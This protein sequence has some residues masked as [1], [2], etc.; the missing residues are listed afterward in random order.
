MSIN[1]INSNNNAT[2]QPITLR[3]TGKSKASAFK[4]NNNS[5]DVVY[6]KH[7][8]PSFWDK[9]K[10]VLGGFA[11]LGAGEIAASKILKSK[12]NFLTSLP[13]VA[14]GMIAGSELAD[15]YL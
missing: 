6:L 8:K 1:S 13:F 11:G 5:D 2:V 15:R 4:A 7:K 3:K 14:A 10:R 12:Y 9:Y